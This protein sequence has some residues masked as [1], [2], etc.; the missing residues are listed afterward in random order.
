M[1][2]VNT[3]IK[4]K[5]SAAVGIPWVAPGLT[6]DADQERPWRF[7]S[8]WSYGGALAL[9]EPSEGVPVYFYPERRTA[10]MRP[11]QTTQIFLPEDIDSEE[12]T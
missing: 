1:A 3:A 12:E 6:N 5:A 7:Q 11:E 9:V 10:I 4:R 2:G 8:A